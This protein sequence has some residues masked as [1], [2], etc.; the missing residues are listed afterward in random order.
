MSDKKQS[1]V[2]WF[3]DKLENHEIQAKHYELFTKAKQMEKEQEQLARNDSYNQ[4]WLEC[5]QYIIKHN[6]QK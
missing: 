6:K 5:S 4:G 2:E 3:F 1:A